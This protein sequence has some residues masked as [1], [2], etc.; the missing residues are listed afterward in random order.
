MLEDWSISKIKY[1]L[2]LNQGSLIL[3]LPYSKGITLY[4][5]IAKKDKCSHDTHP[6][7]MK[8]LF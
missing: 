7:K 8:H 3:E 2:K 6:S 4:K 5:T 1:M